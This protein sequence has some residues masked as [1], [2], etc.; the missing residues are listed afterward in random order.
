MHVCRTEFTQAHVKLC[1]SGEERV[2]SICTMLHGGEER[3][4]TQAS[5]Q[6]KSPDLKKVFSRF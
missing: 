3:A 1:S 4:D 5:Y 2:N 6:G